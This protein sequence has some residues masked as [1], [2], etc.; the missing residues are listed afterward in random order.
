MTRFFVT[1]LNSPPATFTW[2]L[3]HHVRDGGSH[4]GQVSTHHDTQVNLH[5]IS[6][7][8][9]Q[10]GTRWFIDVSRRI[11]LNTDKL[12]RLGDGY[13]GDYLQLHM[14]LIAEQLFFVN[15]GNSAIVQQSYR[16][17]LCTESELL[18]SFPIIHKVDNIDI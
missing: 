18:S 17:W 1:L 7:E 10:I 5:L 2:F 3:L 12:Y 4:V 15:C 16:K 9:G 13:Y 14:L 11:Q 8:S 6:L